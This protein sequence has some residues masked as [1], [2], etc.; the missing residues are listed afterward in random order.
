LKIAVAAISTRFATSA[1]RW[2]KSF[3]RLNPEMSAAAHAAVANV[4]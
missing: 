3:Y 1:C 4:G 2:P